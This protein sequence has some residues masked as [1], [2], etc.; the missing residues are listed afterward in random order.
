M[1]S[2]VVGWTCVFDALEPLDEADLTRTVTIRGEAHSVM[3]AINRQIA[4]YAHHAGQIVVLAKHFQAGRW[5]S[6]S[7]PRGK[8][9]EFNRRVLAG[10]SS[11]R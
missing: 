6:L 9:A 5:K 11:Q 7:I 2:W 8:S 3:Q 10:E 1:V 4:H